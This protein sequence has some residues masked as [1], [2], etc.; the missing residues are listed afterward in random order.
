MPLETVDGEGEDDSGGGVG[1]AL[2][3]AVA[4]RGRPGTSRWR[5]PMSESSTDG[6]I[7]DGGAEVGEDDVEPSGDETGDDDGQEGE[8]GSSIGY[9]SDSIKLKS[10]E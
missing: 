9:D 6:V 2:R 3:V 1:L 4:A 10:S 7:D 5:R 8:G